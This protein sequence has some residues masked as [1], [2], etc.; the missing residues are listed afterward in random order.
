VRDMTKYISP[1]INMILS[2]IA[3]WFYVG[4]FNMR[5]ERSE[6][7]GNIGH[8]DADTEKGQVIGNKIRNSTSKIGRD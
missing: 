1:G 5:L 7:I 6:S 2:L 8:W 4:L 3:M